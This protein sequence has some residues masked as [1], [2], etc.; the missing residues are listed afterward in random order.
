M[1]VHFD[2]LFADF[3]HVNLNKKKESLCGD[4]YMLE[5]KGSD[6]LLVLSDGMGS[7]VKANILAT[8]TAKMLCTMMIKKVPLDDAVETIAST[9]PVCHERQM[10]YATFLAMKITGRQAYVAR[11]D[12]PGLILLRDGRALPYQEKSHFVKEKEIL[13]SELALEKGD[14]LILFSDGV[15]NAGMGKTTDGGWGY[16]EV[17]KF[18]EAKYRPGIS[19]QR[20]AAE[21][22]AA[23][24][25]LNLD[26]TDDDIT[27]LVIRLC[28]RQVTN[29][30]IGPPSKMEKDE[31]FLKTFFRSEGKH[32]VC[33]GT[34]AQFAA[35]YLGETVSVLDGTGTDAVPAMSK[36]KGVD[37]VT[38]G[39]LTLRKLN[40]YA[41]AYLADN[42]DV[43]TTKKKKD[44]AARLLEVLFEESSDINIF[45][46]NASNPANQGLHIDEGEKLRL[47]NHLRNCLEKAGKK[48]RMQI[49]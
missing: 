40:S 33:G 20:M 3:G 45:F 38:E 32:I 19:A 15:T 4:F 31:T 46:G 47:T 41:N 26:E 35:D 16:E 37:L 1:K 22:A 6:T 2:H 36:I 43:L 12:N 7:G 28:E 18:C 27:V 49:W 39:L 14:V 44:G 21:I 9:L 42:M 13:E 17:V 23:C 8:L 34:T 24:V 11:F 25:D 30:M 5:E 10:A 29:L 48:V